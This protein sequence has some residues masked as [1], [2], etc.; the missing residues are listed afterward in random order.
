MREWTSAH[1]IVFVADEIQ[2]GFCRTGDWFACDHEGVVPDLMTLAKGIAGG[3]PLSAVTG[4]ADIMDAVHVGGLGG[5]YGGNPVACA[6]ALGSMQT[7]QEQDLPVRARQIESLVRGRLTAIAGQPPGPA[8]RLP[9]CRFAA[10]CPRVEARCT[11]EPPPVLRD[12]ERDVRCVRPMQR[13]EA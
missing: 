2:T 6:A 13:T 11:T 10:R 9:G 3:L 7:M 5:T 4:R 8:E 1:G 12:G